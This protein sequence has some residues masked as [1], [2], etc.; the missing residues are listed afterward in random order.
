[1]SLTLFFLAVGYA[2]NLIYIFV[3]FLISVAMTG[4]IV[5]NRNVSSIKVDSV[6]AGR[7]FCGEEGRLDVDIHNGS[8]VDSWDVQARLEK[9]KNSD[10]GKTY[11][12]SGGHASLKVPFR[13]ARRG[14]LH[15]PRIVLQSTFPFGLLRAW[16]YAVAQQPVVVYPERRGSIVFPQEAAGGERVQQSGLFKDH[17]PYQ[18][19][20]PLSRIDWR[21]S[22]RRDELLVKNY[23]EPEKPKLKFTWESTGALVETETRLSQL[24]LWVDEAERQGHQYSLKIPGVE[25][26]FASGSAHHD[27]CLTALA[28]YEEG[29]A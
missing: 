28:L 2:N 23:E 27:R 9:N 12:S 1:M 4:M 24:A 25:T 8:P 13:P 20:D 16:K 22:A 7:L 15:P 29:S 26:E 14:L 3:F 10:G 17:R 18:S 5:T 6:T 21:A 19:A 11:V